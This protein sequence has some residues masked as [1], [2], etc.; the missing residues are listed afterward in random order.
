MLAPCRRM[1]RSKVA[2]WGD[3]SRVPTISLSPD[4][5]PQAC[6]MIGIIW[7]SAIGAYRRRQ[8]DVHRAGTLNGRRHLAKAIPIASARPRTSTE[9]RPPLSF[10]PPTSR[11]AIRS[12]NT[13]DQ[14]GACP[15][16]EILLRSDP[17]TAPIIP[18]AR[19]STFPF[20]NAP[21]GPLQRQGDQ[22]NEYRRAHQRPARDR[23]LQRHCDARTSCFVT[24]EPFS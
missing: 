19:I 9:I 22:Q 24:T 1:Q 3:Y 16:S 20:D 12:F 2:G 10:A 23:R 13:A 15:H 4:Q 11:N 17:S 21:M 8:A 14:F 5:L 18:G 7:E 6:R